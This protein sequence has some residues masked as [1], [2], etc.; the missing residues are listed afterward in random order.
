MIFINLVPPKA[1][2]NKPTSEA[3]LSNKT[4]ALAVTKFMIVTD[5]I[6]SHFVVILSRTTPRNQL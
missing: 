5:M 4:R 6:W 3:G 2:A 1:A